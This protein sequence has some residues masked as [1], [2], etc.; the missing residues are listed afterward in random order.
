MC[1]CD[2]REIVDVIELLVST[3]IQKIMEGILNG[4]A[5]KWKLKDR[6]KDEN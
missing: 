1:S 4:K 3:P 2:E 6:L 5:K